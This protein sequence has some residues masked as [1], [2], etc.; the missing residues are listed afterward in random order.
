MSEEEQQPTL[1]QEEFDLRAHEAK[2]ELM[3][4][5]CFTS[6]AGRWV[7][8]DLKQTF[9]FEG[10]GILV[11]GFPMR[12]VSQEAL[13]AVFAN[14]MAKKPIEHICN[15]LTAADERRKSQQQEEDHE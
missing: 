3:Y 12:A 11:D 6:E 5:A 2:R 8:E 7:L 14:Q 4:E 1:E 15:V 9:A 10:S 13:T